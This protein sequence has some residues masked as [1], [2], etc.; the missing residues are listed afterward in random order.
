MAPENSDNGNGGSN[1]NWHMFGR[2]LPKSE[3]VFFI[4]VFLIY[5]VVITSIVNLTINKDEGK[6]WTALLSSSLGYLLPN[7]NLKRREQ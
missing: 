5:I 2:K 3:I 4:Q 7:P 1:H 6:L